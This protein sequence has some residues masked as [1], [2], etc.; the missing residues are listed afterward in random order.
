MLILVS[1]VG[2]VFY[3]LSGPLV[4]NEYLDRESK[5]ELSFSFG[6]CTGDD[7]NRNKVV[8]TTWVDE[9]TILVEAIAAPSCAATWLFG[10]YEVNGEELNLIYSSVISG[11]VACNCGYPVEF[12]ISP[13]IKANYKINLI[14]GKEIYN[15]P[16]LFYKLM[17][18]ETIKQ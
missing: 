15:E 5:P 7:S 11:V 2:S 13:I 4:V 10:D 6:Y 17:G 14:A 16:E 9:E 8:S 1:V 3:M 18:N 12:K